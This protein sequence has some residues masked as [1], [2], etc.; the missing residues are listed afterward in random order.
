[1]PRKLPSPIII[2]CLAL[3]IITGC[4]N[5]QKRVVEEMP[6]LRSQWQT[7]VAHQAALPAR[8]LSWPEAV[9]LLRQKNLKLK[10]AR[11]SVTNSQELERQVFRDL[12]PTINLDGGVS[13][14]LKSL[15][16]TSLDDVTLNVNSFFNVPGV[17][18]FNARLFSTRLG[19]LRAQAALKLA[20]R[21]QIIE[22]YKLF[23]EARENQEQAAEL[24]TER[25]VAET[26][27]KADEISGEVLL[28]DVLMQEENLDKETDSF[29]TR[30][31]DL[32]AERSFRWVLTTDGFPEL[33]YAAHP[34]PL[35]DTNRVAQLQ[36]KMVAIELVGDWAL[37]HGIKLQYWPELSFYVSGPSV[38]QYE[39][40]QGKFVS[41][42]NIVGSANF[43]WS[44]DTRGY[45][46]QQ[47]KNVRRSQD[48]EKTQLRLDALALIDRLLAAQKAEVTLRDQASQLDRLLAFLDKM[49]PDPDVNSVLQRAETNRSLH[50]Q[51]A[52]LRRDL[53]EL[54]TLFW[55]VDEEQWNAKNNELCFN[56]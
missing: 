31:G 7:N 16:T 6:A 10:A 51:R 54:N 28:K 1:V 40:N 41:P 34:L 36:M 5:P 3:L 33:D 49:P 39:G 20:E 35:T 27:K 17:V 55:F 22:L 37:V 48:I 44:L 45:I 4:A 30:A 29:Q 8:D 24:K 18:N 43:F 21:E 53:A 50:F 52:H 47:L 26:V 32:L 9:A 13:K 19:V 25:S 56:H 14:S 12:T 2:T 42:A 23:L 15:P 11:I 46:S 38:F